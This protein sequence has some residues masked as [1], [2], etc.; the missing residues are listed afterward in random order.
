M[1]KLRQYPKTK[2]EDVFNYFNNLDSNRNLFLARKAAGFEIS[3]L[4][5]IFQEKREELKEFYFS[6][7]NQ[8][9]IYEF[10]NSTGLEKF[11]L[12]LKQFDVSYI[13]KM[14]AHE[15]SHYKKGK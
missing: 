7:I 11:L 4:T 2:Y 13:N 5:K 14:V 12:N 15:N 10:K 3:K 9:D 6:K 8:N 1:I